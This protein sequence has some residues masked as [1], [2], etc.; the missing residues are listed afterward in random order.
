MNDSG[1]GTK[2]LDLG[3]EDGSLLGADWSELDGDDLLRGTTEVGMDSVSSNCLPKCASGEEMVWL[4]QSLHQGDS[5]WDKVCAC[6]AM[7]VN[8]TTLSTSQV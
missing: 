5:G 8:I 3:E 1:E 6:D 7:L 4:C 2:G